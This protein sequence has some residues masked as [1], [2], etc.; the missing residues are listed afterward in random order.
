MR[1]VRLFGGLSVVIIGCVGAL[2]ACGGDDTTTPINPNADGGGNKDQSV[3][4]FD[5]GGQNDTGGNS[6]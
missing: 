4:D 2:E 3:P 6:S 5:S 1:S